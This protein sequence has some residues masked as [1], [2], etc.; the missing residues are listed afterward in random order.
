MVI[1]FEDVPL[2]EQAEENFQQNLP[3]QYRNLLKDFKKSLRSFVFFNCS[4]LALFIL[5]VVGISIFWIY[6]ISYYIPFLLG[7]IFLTSFFY[8]ILFFYLQT[9]KPESLQLIAENFLEKL[10]KHISSS[11]E[12]TA[13][14][15]SI[16]HALLRLVDYLEG[17]E[18]QLYPVSPIFSILQTF[19]EKLSIYCHWK[20]IICMKELLLHFAIQEHIALIRFT[21]TDLEL[22]TSLANC[23]VGLSRVYLEPKKLFSANFFTRK[24]KKYFPYFEEK[25][26]KVSK[27]AIEEFKILNHYAPED[28]WIHLQLA[29][30]YHDL[31]MPQ[32]EIEEY[33]IIL[34]LRPHD[35]EILFR[36]GALYFEQGFNAKGLKIY[37][38]LKQA[39]YEKI[40][41]LI[42]F[43]GSFNDKPSFEDIL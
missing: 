42:H 4:F 10:K 17:F 29:K 40:D 20:D 1:Q 18:K 19:F 39:N 2:D 21:P 8:F 12:K 34:Q 6:E 16:A 33:E 23:Y 35:K 25:F 13:H 38:L 43:F 9:K 32:L 28:P 37:D 26:R 41:E 3:H 7:S 5:Q 30:S 22:H 14:H 15:L 31:Y 36:L 24:I 27:K 11:S